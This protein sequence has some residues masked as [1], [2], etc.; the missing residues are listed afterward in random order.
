MLPFITSK[1]ALGHVQCVLV[2]VMYVIGSCVEAVKYPY[3]QT[4]WKNL[5]VNQTKLNPFSPGSFR[6]V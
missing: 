6:I 3:D 4:Q 2:N 5:K 1:F